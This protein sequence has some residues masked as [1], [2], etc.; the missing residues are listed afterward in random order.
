ML[1]DLFPKASTRYLSLPVLG[2]F[3]ADFENWLCERG[4]TRNSRQ[5]LLRAVA[6]ID[7]YLRRRGTQVT[8]AGLDACWRCAR[9]RDGEVAGTVRSLMLFLE[10]YGH[11]SARVPHPPTRTDACVHAYAAALRDL[12]GLTAK[13]IHE[14]VRTATEFLDQLAY[15]AHPERLA[16]VGPSDVEGFVRTTGARLSRGTLQHTLAALRSFLR[17]LVA[18]GVVH[19][20][21]DTQIDMPRLYQREQLPRALPW[22]TVHAFLASIDRTTPVGLRDYTMFFLIA[23]YGLRASE[24]VALT[25]DALDWGAGVL[26]VAPR[27]HGTPLDLPLTDAA[28]L[29]LLE[30]LRHGRPPSAP[31][32]VSASPGAR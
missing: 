29:V 12:R 15:E 24:V 2:L 11:L 6:Q 8:R 4:Y 16:T 22:E 14:H 27:K 26:H 28:G 7:R 21:L 30:Y 5:H 18:G 23:T 17:F 25:L 3:T 1:R 13:T 32:A 10:L 31:R 9:R 19:P 20:G